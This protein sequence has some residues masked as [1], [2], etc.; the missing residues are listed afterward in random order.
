VRILAIGSALRAICADQAAL[1][2][3]FVEEAWTAPKYRLY[4]IDD[5][6]AALVEDAATG[7]SVRGELVDVDESRW[8]QVLASEPPG[9]TQAPIELADG[10]VVTAATG[11][12]A[13]MSEAA[14]D[15]SAYGDFAAYVEARNAGRVEDG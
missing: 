14:R 15:I 1:G 12:P 10:R 13:R 7:V 8:E 3:T 9:V 4:S 5:S 11:D 2:L 6:H